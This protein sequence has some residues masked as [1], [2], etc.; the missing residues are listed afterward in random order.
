MSQFN[1]SWTSFT[2]YSLPITSSTSLRW[3]Y[4]TTAITFSLLVL[5][6]SV[7][8]YKKRHLPGATWTI[9]I[10]GKFADSLNPTMEG[11][12]KQWNL[13]ALSAISVFNMYSIFV[14]LSHGSKSSSTPPIRRFIVMASSNEYARKILNSPQYAEPCI[15]ASGRQILSP[16]NWYQFPISL[17]SPS[18]LH[19]RVFLTGK[20]HVDYRRPLNCLFTRK[21]LGSVSP[22]SAPPPLS[23][24]L[25]TSLECTS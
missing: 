1:D 23:S 3:L 15:V 2:E 12:K 9:P 6:Q 16:G 10:I 18:H 5:E 14:Y 4:T 11:Y 25:K 24:H 8:R 7:Y 22:I 20:K 17:L 13:G 19:R 21:A